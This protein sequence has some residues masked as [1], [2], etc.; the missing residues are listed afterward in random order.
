MRKANEAIQRIKHPMPTMVDLIADL[1]SS[2]V[3][4]KLNL[5]NAYYQLELRESSRHTTTFA[6][7][8]RLLRYKH[9]L[10]GVKAASELF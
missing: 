2:N 7:H 1:N 3:F 6:T 8:A 4:S 5:S 9:L 10:F